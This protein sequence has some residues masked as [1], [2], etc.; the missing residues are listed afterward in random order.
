MKEEKHLD[1]EEFIPETEDQAPPELELEEEEAQ[2]GDKMKA[3]REKLKV[4][5]EEKM[6]HLENLQRTKAD[7]L[8]SKKRLEE[9]LSRDTERITEG[10]IQDLLP[11]CDSFT[12]AMANKEAW[13]AVDKN[14]RVGVEGIHAQLK[15]ILTM[16]GVTEIHP[17]GE[18]FDPERHEAMKIEENADAPKDTVLKVIQYGYERNGTIIRPAKVI[19]SNS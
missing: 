13:E 18:V 4:C 1:E 6:Q 8:N 7:F 15:N 19:I 11:L 16:H 9:Q 14:W 5:E 2:S 17:E 12:M 10:F 3:L